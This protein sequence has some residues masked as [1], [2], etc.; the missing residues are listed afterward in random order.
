MAD[1]LVNE[2]VK[3]VRRQG[4]EVRPTTKGYNL[5]APNG[6]DIVLI[7]KTPSHQRWIHEAVAKIRAADPNFRWNR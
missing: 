4:W 1:K 6:R 7:H 2:L 3:A 5:L